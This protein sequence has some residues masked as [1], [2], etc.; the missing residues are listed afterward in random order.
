MPRSGETSV[1]LYPGLP[2]RVYPC[3]RCAGGRPR[4]TA[5]GLSF[6]E[7]VRALDVA[8]WIRPLTIVSSDALPLVRVSES[9]LFR[10]RSAVP[11]EPQLPARGAGW[12]NSRSHSRPVLY[13]MPLRTS[14]RIT[15]GLKMAVRT[16]QDIHSQRRTHAG[17]EQQNSFE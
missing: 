4:P 10:A 3:V 11:L 16:V 7:C 9:S 13:F 15:A 2:F 1:F 14:T 12:G 8:G 5:W 17:N 6:D